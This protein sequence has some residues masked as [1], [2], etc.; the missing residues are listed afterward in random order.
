VPVSGCGNTPEAVTKMYSHEHFCFFESQY[1][2]SVST[3]A[4][5]IVWLGFM[6]QTNRLTNFLGLIFGQPKVLRFC[7]K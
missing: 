7:Q 6:Q 3:H 5:G 2:S 4:L 1:C